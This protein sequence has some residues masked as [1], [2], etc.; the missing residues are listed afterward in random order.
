MLKSIKI[1]L[2]D[3]IVYG[4]GNIAV[5]IVG[6]LLIPV[7]TIRSSFQLISSEYLEYL[8]FVPSY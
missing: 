3:T 7:Y 4:L 2:K 8:R 6:L 5:K 1:S